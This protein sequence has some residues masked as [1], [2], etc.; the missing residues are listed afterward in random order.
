LTIKEISDD[1]IT[2][3]KELEIDVSDF[4]KTHQILDKLGYKH[5]A[6]QENKRESYKLGDVDFEIDTWPKIPPYLEIEGSSE[7][8][9]ENAVKSLGYEMKDT[10]SINTKKLYLKNNIDIDDFK[11]LTFE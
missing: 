11:E 4:E 9:V 7:E 3:T 5:K 10:T 1:S 6:L 8:K 2:G